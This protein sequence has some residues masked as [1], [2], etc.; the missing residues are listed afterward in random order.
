MSTR[1]YTAMWIILAA[2]AHS[3]GLTNHSQSL[4]TKR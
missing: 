2:P 1:K 4:I 3:P